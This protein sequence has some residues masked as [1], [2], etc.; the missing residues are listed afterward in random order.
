[1]KPRSNRHKKRADSVL[2]AVRFQKDKVDGLDAIA[3]RK[4]VTRSAVIKLAVAEKI[5]R[6]MAASSK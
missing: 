2:V 3:M 5:E 6:E 1:M 4:G